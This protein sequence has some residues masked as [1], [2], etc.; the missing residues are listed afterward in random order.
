MKQSAAERPD[1][2]I[3]RKAAI[4]R[5]A[6]LEHTGKVQIKPIP[7]FDLDRT[8]FKTLEGRAARYV[9][10]TRVGKEAHFDTS[11]A[12]AVQAEY[13][14]ARAAHPL[15]GVAPELMNF[16][17]SECDFNVEHADGSFLDHLYFCFEYS[18]QHYPKRSAL[19]MMLHSILGTGTNTF[20]MTADKIPALQPLMTP[21]EWTHVE[22]F[23]SV[24]R[25]LYAGPLRKELRENA[26]RANA[27]ASINFYRVIDNAPITLSGADLW[28][29]LNYQLI[30]LVDFLPVANWSAHQNDTS[31]ILFRDL[32]ELLG[33]AG[34]REAVVAYTPSTGPRTSEGE[35]QGIGEWLTTLIPVRVSERMAAKSVARFSA[36]IGHSL[37]YQITWA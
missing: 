37:D 31:F 4:A 3:Q 19:V 35:L 17:V 1:P 23:P 25:L 13:A 2:T 36:R 33:L 30:H 32:Y 18:A 12:R 29:A 15:P 7:K 34:K 21:W 22:A 16:L 26:H 9:M 27:L 5:G 11:A 8:I 20:A 6:A 24:L 14:A 10:T 28:I